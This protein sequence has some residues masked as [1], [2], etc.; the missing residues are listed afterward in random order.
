MQFGFFLLSIA[1]FLDTGACTSGKELF[2][3]SQLWIWQDQWYFSKKPNPFKPGFYV[4]HYRLIQNYVVVLIK[5]W[6]V[7]LIINFCLKFDDECVGHAACLI[8]CGCSLFFS[9][10]VKSVITSQLEFKKQNKTKKICLELGSVS[11]ARTSC[12]KQKE[13]KG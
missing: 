12:P 8:L 9:F 11:N 4:A 5:H 13:Q 7:F 1:F 3:S 2:L 6:N 10:H